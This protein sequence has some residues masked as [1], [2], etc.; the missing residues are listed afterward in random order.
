MGFIARQKKTVENVKRGKAGSDMQL[1]LAGFSARFSWRGGGGG[2]RHLTVLDS[3]P[4]HQEKDALTVLLIARK[5][6]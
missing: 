2:R 5:I 3:I 4:D 1:L 6:S